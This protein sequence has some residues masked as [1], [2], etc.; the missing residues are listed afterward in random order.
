MALSKPFLGEGT[1]INRLPSFN[2][3]CYDYWKIRMKIFIKSQDLDVWDAI[4]DGPYVPFTETNGAKL[5]KPRNEWSDEDKK[6]VQ[7][8][9][10]AKNILTSALGFHELFR[11]SNC[12]TVK[13]C[14][15]P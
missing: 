12:T 14:G 9:L 7:Y 13:E 2:G 15:T 10:R 1:S 3:E 11:I 6:K 4:Q 5:A 8:D